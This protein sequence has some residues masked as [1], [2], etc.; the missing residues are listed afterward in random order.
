M[1]HVTALSSLNAAL[2]TLAFPLQAVKTWKA[3]SAEDLSMGT[4][5]MVCVSVFCWLIYGLLIEDL[6]IIL[7]NAV[8]LVL[9][10]S[11]LALA[12]VYRRQARE[13]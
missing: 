7:A 3:K 11:V 2:I 12:V 1:T 13:A 9:V 6:P 5:S 10:R 4:L 8:T